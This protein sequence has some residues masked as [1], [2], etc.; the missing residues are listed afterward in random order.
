MG[1]DPWIGDPAQ[2][3]ISDVLSF[4]PTLEAALKLSGIWIYCGKQLYERRLNSFSFRMSTSWAL[5]IFR[6]EKLLSNELFI[7]KISSFKFREAKT[8][9]FV[10]SKHAR[11]NFFLKLY[12]KLSL[13]IH[14]FI[15]VQHVTAMLKKMKTNFMPG[16]YSCHP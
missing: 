5:K 15:R 16:L 3:C 11:N 9:P 6:N 10:N 2:L 4:Q 8:S 12:Q 1:G 13:C 7:R 14:S